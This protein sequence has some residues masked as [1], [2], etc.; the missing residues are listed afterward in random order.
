[1]MPKTLPAQAVLV[2]K[3]WQFPFGELMNKREKRNHKVLKSDGR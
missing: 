2:S 3:E 1:M